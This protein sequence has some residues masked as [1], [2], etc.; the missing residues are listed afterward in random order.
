MLHFERR[1]IP[2][3]LHPLHVL[4]RAGLSRAS[5]K[6]TVVDISRLLESRDSES[7]AENKSTSSIAQTSTTSATTNSTPGPP[8][9]WSSNS[10][11]PPYSAIAPNIA[12]GVPTNTLGK[13]PP[14]LPPVST[15]H[16][17]TLHPPPYVSTQPPL[18][19]PAIQPYH[20][21]PPAVP[22][23]APLSSHNLPPLSVS[24][25]PALSASLQPHVPHLQSVIPAKRGADP[26]SQ[27]S[28]QKKHHGKWTEEE[29]NL[30]IELRRRGMKWE[31]IAKRIPGRSA[32]S[33]RLRY[34]NYSEKRPAWDEEKKNKLARLYNR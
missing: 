21:T 1:G 19:I 14:Q 27:S 8:R 34:Q 28:P 3:E 20:S 18:Y 6:T 24:V 23:L 4:A 11:L 9:S 31:D 29:D 2:Q 15:F 12:P 30:A 10:G 32:I 25:P 17:G 22:A 13:S 5:P 16:S 26:A 7:P 33:C